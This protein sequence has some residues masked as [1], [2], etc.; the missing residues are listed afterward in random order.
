[1]FI[2]IFFLNYIPKALICGIIHVDIILGVIICL[3]INE[4][5]SRGLRLRS[6]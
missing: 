3:I 1:M 4:E 2:I 6:S 5:E